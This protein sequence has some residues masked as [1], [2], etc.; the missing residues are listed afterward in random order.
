[1]YIIIIIKDVFFLTTA[2]FCSN[3]F[4]IILVFDQELQ[5]LIREEASRFYNILMYFVSKI[6]LEIPVNIM[7]TLI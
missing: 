4:A 6:C 3:V 2:I 5:V 1:M 7:S